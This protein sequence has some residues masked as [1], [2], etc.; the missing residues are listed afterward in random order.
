[1]NQSPSGTVQGRPLPAEPACPAR[2]LARGGQ[3]LDPGAGFLLCFSLKSGTS[4][5][6]KAT[7]DKSRG[8]PAP[9]GCGSEAAS[10]AGGQ[11]G[12]ADVLSAGSGKQ[13]SYWLSSN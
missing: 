5:F 9:P 10:L 8:L 13:I 11:A 4:A 6:A 7:A 3:V 2:V 1:M 12:A